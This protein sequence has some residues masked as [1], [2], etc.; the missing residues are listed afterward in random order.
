MRTAVTRTDAR[1]PNF[2]WHKPPHT[3]TRAAP[4]PPYHC[5][6]VAGGQWTLSARNR[7]VT[8]PIP[9][10]QPK[11]NPTGSNI[12]GIKY[13]YDLR[14]QSISAAGSSTMSAL[15]TDPKMRII[16]ALAVMI[17]AVGG[18]YGGYRLLN[19]EAGVLPLSA[20]E[21]LEDQFVVKFTDDTPNEVVVAMN[22]EH[23]V[24]QLTSI[25]QLGVSLMQIPPGF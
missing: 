16:T 22:S 23:G 14:P 12:A 20:S 4:Q 21:F 13:D 9:L 18:G 10:S 24:E 1:L 3:V 25:P 2:G 8:S 11:V 6:P 7:L 15:L 5:P 19:P 17:L